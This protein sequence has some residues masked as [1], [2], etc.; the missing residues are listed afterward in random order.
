MT[1]M[2][3]N[4]GAPP[5]PGAGEASAREQ[6]AA[7]AL[8]LLLGGA[9]ALLNLLASLAL[10]PAVERFLTERALGTPELQ[11]ALREAL[12]VL[13]GPVTKVLTLLRF[14][15][16]GLMT[17]GA[18]QMKQLKR[19]PLA[20]T[21]AI[22]GLLPGGCC[23]LTLPVGIWA[24]VVLLKPEVRAAFRAPAARAP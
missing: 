9:L 5:P 15:S 8:L 24:L 20:V 18:W 1:P 2:D 11:Q 4:H 3:P 22:L 6:L 12:A 23:C 14:A 19:Y 21:A 16:S 17:W 10:Q 7:P 13:D